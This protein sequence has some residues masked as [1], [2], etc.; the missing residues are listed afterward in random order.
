MQPPSPRLGSAPHGFGSQTRNR[1]HLHP[2][3]TSGE[4]SAACKPPTR[5]ELATVSTDAAAS[6]ARLDADAKQLRRRR[7]PVGRLLR[8]GR[9][10]RRRG[11][12]ER[13]GRRAYGYRR[14]G[15]EEVADVEPGRPTRTPEGEVS[16]RRSRQRLTQCLDGLDVEHRSVFVLFEVEGMRSAEIA[17]TLGVPVGTIYSRLHHARAR[18]RE[19]YVALGRGTKPIAE[20]GGS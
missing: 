4:L 17:E 9:A 12:D 13:A 16:T 18:V 7:R 20:G 15:K 10:R 1:H 2:R 8:G 3:N 11:T 5:T 6:A 14:K 19:A